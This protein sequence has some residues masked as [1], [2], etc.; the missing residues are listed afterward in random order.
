MDTFI[1]NPKDVIQKWHHIDASGQILGRMAVLIANI[2]RGK[3]K[4]YFSPHMDCGDFVIVT[5]AEKIEVT[6][7]KAEQKEYIHH[8]QHPGGFR[9]KSYKVMLSKHPER[10]IE[11]AVW[12]MIPHNHLG[13]RLIR[14]LKV[15]KGDKHPHI[16]QKPEELVINFKKK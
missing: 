3:N 12:G 11:K 9:C 8:T 7:K 15:Y 14:K 2:L 6:G 16:A 4:P 10:I 5:N 1:I 13:R